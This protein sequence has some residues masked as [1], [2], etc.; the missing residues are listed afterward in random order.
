MSSIYKNQDA[1]RMMLGLAGGQ[2]RIA[3]IFDGD[4]GWCVTQEVDDPSPADASARVYRVTCFGHCFAGTLAEALAT[5]QAI[6]MGRLGRTD[7]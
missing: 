6:R 3:L 1:E 2:G 7:S 4:Q 5:A